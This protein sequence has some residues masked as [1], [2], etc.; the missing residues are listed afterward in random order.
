MIL[1]AKE[2][3]KK[4]LKHYGFSGTWYWGCW[5]ESVDDAIYKYNEAFIDEFSFD[6]YDSIDVEEE[7]EV[8]VEIEEEC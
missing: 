7:R 4:I 5:A 8:E 3:E 6:G 1:L 2:K